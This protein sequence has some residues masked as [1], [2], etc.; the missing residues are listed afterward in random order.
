MV[1]NSNS[2]VK[3]SVM[4][5]YR[6]SIE[7]MIQGYHVYKNIWDDPS[8]DKELWC[9]REPGNPSDPYAVA[10][11]KLLLLIIDYYYFRLQCS[12]GTK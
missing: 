2:G 9:K 5:A 8:V 6:F 1:S 10:M 12:L 7:S 3:L 11:I 4:S